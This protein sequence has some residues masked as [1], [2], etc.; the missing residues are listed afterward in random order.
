MA[1]KG[2][3]SLLQKMRWVLNFLHLKTQSSN[4]WIGWS[5]TLLWHEIHFY[6]N[7]RRHSF[8]SWGCRYWNVTSIWSTWKYEWIQWV[9]R[10]EREVKQTL[11]LAAAETNSAG[12]FDLSC[13]R[14]YKSC[15]E[16]TV[17]QWTDCS[18]LGLS[19]RIS[20]KYSRPFCTTR[21][22]FLFCHYMMLKMIDSNSIAIF[23]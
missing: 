2:E 6:K 18:S 21:L 10:D 22:A 15:D 23:S 19:C 7:S 13:T 1:H 14:I 20:H 3:M 9:R 12:S 8:D 5:I 17:L 11:T 4:V 16:L